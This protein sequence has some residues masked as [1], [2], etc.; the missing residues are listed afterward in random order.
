MQPLPLHKPQTQ[1]FTAVLVNK[2]PYNVHYEELKVEQECKRKLKAE[3]K[4][5]EKVAK[6]HKRANRDEDMD[7]FAEY[8]T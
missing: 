5:I 1:P 6:E 8:Y 2:R 3:E 7:F 4:R